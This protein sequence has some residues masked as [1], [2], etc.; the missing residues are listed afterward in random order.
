MKVT[1]QDVL[2]N[3]NRDALGIKTRPRKGDR[4]VVY[5][6]GK[7][8]EVKMI[9]QLVHAFK[10]HYRD[11]IG[12][13]PCRASGDPYTDVSVSTICLAEFRDNRTF[14][15]FKGLRITKKVGHPNEE[16]VKKCH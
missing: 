3:M 10:K 1:P 13:F 8:L 7:N 16:L 12:L 11:G 4:L 15:C 5:V 6:C 14:Q 2:G 9:I